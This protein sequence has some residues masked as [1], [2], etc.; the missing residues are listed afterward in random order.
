MHYIQNDE[1][2][3]FFIDTNDHKLSLLKKDIVK[4]FNKAGKCYTVVSGGSMM[5][6]MD[7]VENK[8]TSLFY[9]HMTLPQ[10]SS[11]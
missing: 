2:I 4:L 1:R 6:H 11:K 10:L 9:K 3:L 8:N 7:D 5:F